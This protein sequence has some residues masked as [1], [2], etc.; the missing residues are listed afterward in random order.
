MANQVRLYFSG[1]SAQDAVKGEVSLE[2][3]TANELAADGDKI[4]ALD[5]TLF[6]SRL[7]EVEAYN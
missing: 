4:F 2:E 5:V 7:R 1:R 3:K 6:A